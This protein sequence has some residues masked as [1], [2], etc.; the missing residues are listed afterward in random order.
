MR[1]RRL[2][3]GIAGPV[4]VL[5]L[6]VPALAG[7]TTYTGSGT[8]HPKVKVTLERR[9]ARIKHVLFKPVTYSCTHGPPGPGAIG[10]GGKAKLIEAHNEINYPGPLRIA[11]D[12]SF[13]YHHVV[14]IQG[15]K[16]NTARFTVRASG[17]FHGHSVSG[18]VREVRKFPP[19]AGIGTCVT[20]TRWSAK[21]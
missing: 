19:G 11:N 17:H 4:A 10:I 14:G 12:G 1:R 13:T 16:A 18:K 20:S 2:I 9:G 21:R 8:N 5:G 3:A 6:V 7:T 15:G